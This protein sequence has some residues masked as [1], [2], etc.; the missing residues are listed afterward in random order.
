MAFFDSVANGTSNGGKSVAAEQRPTNNGISLTGF[1]LSSVD[2][3]YNAN[4]KVNEHQYQIFI[5]DTGRAAAVPMKDVHDKKISRPLEGGNRG[6]RMVRA[7]GTSIIKTLETYRNVNVAYNNAHDNGDNGRTEKVIKS[8]ARSTNKGLKCY[9]Y[10]L[11]TPL[12]SKWSELAV[13]IGQARYFTVRVSEKDEVIP[14]GQFVTMRGI[15][16]DLFASKPKA[17]K[18]PDA[19]EAAADESNAYTEE[20]DFLRDNSS[21]NLLGYKLRCDVVIGKDLSQSYGKLSREHL[22]RTLLDIGRQEPEY[23]KP[24]EFGRPFKCLVFP[25]DEK[26]AAKSEAITSGIIVYGNSPS[27]F[28]KE[29]T[30][31][32]DAS[33]SKTYDSGKVDAPSNC[34]PVH[35]KLMHY[36][37]VPE[38]ISAEE[39]AKLNEC[40]AESAPENTGSKNV[41]FFNRATIDSIIWSSQTYASGITGSAYW[42]DT[43]AQARIPCIAIAMP[44]R[45]MAHES[46]LRVRVL[47]VAW[48]TK[49]YVLENSFEVPLPFAREILGGKDATTGKVV[50]GK[51]PATNYRPELIITNESNAKRGHIDLLNATESA[52]D[53]KPY[54]DPANKWH[55]RVQLIANS[56]DL[57]SA[58][59]RQQL[60]MAGLVEKSRLLTTPEE[61]QAFI[62]E[63]VKDK[64]AGAIELSEFGCNQRTHRVIVWFVRHDED[65]YDAALLALP[66]LVDLTPPP[67]TTPM[68]IVENDNPL[69]R[70][71]EE[72]DIVAGAKEE[73]VKE[74]D[75]KKARTE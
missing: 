11:E 3:G 13:T 23:E 75:V 17:D 25:V 51:E 4:I 31:D 45:Y 26:G 58:N 73:A 50:F 39:R 69:K 64:H 74:P 56:V 29:T 15:S 20:A 72:K 1:V 16:L 60:L 48:R 34:L 32:L 70:P 67:A 62:E 37:I 49:E 68:V 41:V 61:G 12:L 30:K 7:N 21:G 27:R 5:M 22:F 40:F 14:K 8:V 43:N 46:K 2:R 9:D 66:P 33:N 52:V 47:A 65:V 59:E 28:I 57:A 42:C 36:R 54:L 18:K 10:N 6:F 24:G 19:D 53:L 38:T 35:A 71:L 63:Y 55:A 44:L